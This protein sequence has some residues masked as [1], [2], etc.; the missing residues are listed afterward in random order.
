MLLLPM[1]TE[2]EREDMKPDLE[3]I[4]EWLNKNDHLRGTD[5]Y[6]NKEQEATEIYETIH[7]I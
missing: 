6:K 3:K 1:Y 4:I 5:Q 2:Q 7:G